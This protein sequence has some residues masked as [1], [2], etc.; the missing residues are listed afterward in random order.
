[1][2]YQHGGCCCSAFRSENEALHLS[3]TMLLLLWGNAAT[4]TNTAQHFPFMS[5]MSRPIPINVTYMLEVVVHVPA[6]LVPNLTWNIDPLSQL[7]SPTNLLTFTPFDRPVQRSPCRSQIRPPFLWPADSS[8]LP[9]FRAT[10]RSR[11]SAIDLHLQDSCNAPVW[12]ID[13]FVPS[14]VWRSS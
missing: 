2:V 7:S 9:I 4:R 10:Q 1:M 14:L 13:S 8:F 11:L 12:A 5:P 3:R 6:T